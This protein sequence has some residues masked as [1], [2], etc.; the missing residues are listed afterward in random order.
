MT[1]A[2]LRILFVDDERR[3][4][5]GLRRTLRPLAA[6][7]DLRFVE[8]GEQALQ[9]LEQNEADVVVSDMRMPGM[10]GAQLLA[11]VRAL[12]P[13]TIRLALSGQADQEEVMGSVGPVQQ[14]L[15]K[16]CD[17]EML[18]ASIRRLFSLRA[19]L[20]N[21]RLRAAAGKIEKLPAAP[22]SYQRLIEVL[23]DPES[24]VDL[25]GAV[26]AQDPAMTAKCLQL[27]NSAFF[28]VARP[29]HTAT[30][31]VSR[32]GLTTIRSLALV[33]RVFEA[34]GKCAVPGLTP[35]AIWRR[36]C[37][38]ASR[39]RA[40]AEKLSLHPDIQDTVYT[41]GMLSE[42]G[43]L[44]LLADDPE[45]MA[46]LLE[47]ARKQSRPL[48]D[49][50]LES[51]SATQ[52]QVGSYLLGLWGFSDTCVN[53]VAFHEKP[54]NA[55]TTTPDG[56]TALHLAICLNPA[57][58]PDARPW[59]VDPDNEYLQAVGAADVAQRFFAKP[60]VAA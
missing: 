37:L 54:S 13:Q 57:D 59:C 32:L 4:L 19:A 7:W 22:E 47:S 21:P 28:G 16:P 34:F 60:G 15:M 18:R 10:S 36:S 39:A 25:V 48:C 3:I 49:I 12:Y 30:E 31:A 5:D 35:D 1:P 44:A 38:T 24:S 56:I 52:A 43:R 51:L 27:V 26:V 29:A 17:P 41:A 8:G 9:A 2:K 50:E 20:E 6:D 46:S 42:I 23:D 14:F 11:K 55:A 33:V 58:P 40:A 45:H 53:A